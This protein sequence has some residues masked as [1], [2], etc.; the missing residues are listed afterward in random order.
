MARV[1]CAISGLPFS[2]DYLEGLSIPHT[3]GYFH[4][5]FAVEYKHLLRLYT[6]HSHGK[7]TPK[8]SYL[9]FLAILHSSDQ[10]TW[11]APASLDP[12]DNQT[13]RLIENNMS[14]LIEVLEKTALIKHP[15]FEQP[16]FVVTYD[17]SALL[18]IPNWIKAWK[19][20]I[21]SFHTGRYRLLEI[22]TLQKVENK[23]T[24]LILSGEKREKFSHVI[25]DWASKAAEFPPDKIEQ[26]KLTIRSCYNMNKMF[27]T[28]LSLLKEIKDHC[29]CNIEAGSIHFHTLIQVLKKGI[30]KHIDYLGGS[31]L[32][33]GYT[34]LPVA[35]EKAEL[36]NQAEL[37][38]LTANAPASYPKKEDYGTSL[39]FIK[40][41]L[42]YNVSSNLLKQKRIL[43]LKENTN[44]QDI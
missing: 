7:L 1:T 44:E 40:A 29:E 43:E 41:K 9:L 31:T 33:L 11:K 8:D 16:S 3:L 24:K 6:A 37:A 30:S 4:P 18:Q 39:D 35:A 14:Q 28:P 26:Y 27:N 17:N 12:N 36:K 20:N 34:L 32:A 2:T 13:K 19:A 5:I 23:L 22:Q 10:I 25:A 42:A 38:T 15:S 21:I